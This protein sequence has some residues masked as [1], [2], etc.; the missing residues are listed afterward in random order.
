MI[1]WKMHFDTCSGE[2]ISIRFT[3]TQSQEPL[4]A[5]DWLYLHTPTVSVYDL[6]PFLASTK[7]RTWRFSS[8]MIS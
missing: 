6:R 4:V 5:A 7:E 8:S 3:C 1:P 2:P